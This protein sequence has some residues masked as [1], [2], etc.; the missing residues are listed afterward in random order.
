MIHNTDDLNGS[1]ERE[2][3]K[4]QLKQLFRQWHP[5]IVGNSTG[6]NFSVMHILSELNT[7]L[8]ERQLANL[9]DGWPDT[10][11]DD[12]QVDFPSNISI[13]LPATPAAFVECLSRYREGVLQKEHYP[14]TKLQRIRGSET[15]KEPERDETLDRFWRF[16]A[17]SNSVDDLMR[18]FDLFSLYSED[19][20]REIQI[21][22]LIDKR[23]TFLF[24]RDAWQANNEEDIRVILDRVK[25][26]S[27]FNESARD[28][29]V[30]TI[31]TRVSELHPKTL[32]PTKQRLTLDEISERGEI[33][34]EARKAF[35]ERIRSADSEA[36]LLSLDEEIR[37]FTFFNRG[38]LGVV[39]SAISRKMGKKRGLDK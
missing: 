1:S 21:P 31:E 9:Q 14:Q 10:I 35:I 30:S 34:R 29:I 6:R 12:A 26:F 3:T 27:F 15:R 20:L 4:A 37:S 17:E 24:V 28:H 2:R 25:N 22:D 32:T 13:F 39:R 11:P 19:Q 7:S 16:I 38:E 18:A 5:D 23:A 8:N 36:E 33:E